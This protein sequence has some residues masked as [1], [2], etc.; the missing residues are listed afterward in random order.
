MTPSP[1]AQ[2]WATPDLK[3]IFYLNFIPATIPPDAATQLKD[4]KDAL[5]LTTDWLN[6]TGWRR[7][8]EADSCWA[9][10]ERYG[11][12]FADETRN[13]S[14]RRRQFSDGTCYVVS[15]GDVDE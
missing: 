6:V 1:L 15:Q 12:G 2:P 10:A 14:C 9:I 7:D 8:S 5:H 4:L 3:N 13:S 11:G